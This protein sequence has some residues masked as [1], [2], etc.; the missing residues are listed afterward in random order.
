LIFS[1]NEVIN[2]RYQ[3][4]EYI[5]AGGMQE[6]YCAFDKILQK[7]VALKTP[8]NT[9]AEK[10]FQRSAIL[11]AKVNH[12][13]IAKTLDYF[14]TSQRAF[15][16]EE[17]ISGVSLNK[18]LKESMWY[19][20]HYLLAQFGH[21]MA[22]GVSAAH[23]AKVIHRDL[24][25]GNIMMEKDEKGEY[26]FKITDFGIAK[27]AEDEFEEAYKD[28]QSITGSQ[29]MFGA[30]PF[31]SPEM[32]NGPKEATNASDVWAIGAILYK[33]MTGNEPYGSGLQAVPKIYNAN[34]PTNPV[35]SFKENP[36]FIN[37][38][39]QI[40]GIIQKC[41]QK[42][43]DLRPTADQL[44]QEFS[45]LCYGVFP[46]YEGSI[47]NYK[48][49]EGDWGFLTN[50]TGFS[51]TF[52]HKESFYGEPIGIVQNCKVQYSKHHGGGSDRAFPVLPLKAFT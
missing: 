44:T 12:P 26:Q 29:T 37:L 5:D 20:D 30:I 47:K 1:N 36:Q 45:N 33:V 32:L 41:L 2:S 9:H 28:E 49:Y 3:I 23:H 8:K 4:V 17:L 14:E 25:P 40:W 31:M 48:Q 50:N 46:R 13:N 15:L 24:K 7:R 51:D 38:T 35:V 11:S 27:L 52:F 16:I 34:L 43:P 39:S 19:F 10:R 6:V 18:V 42:D 22:K 21:H